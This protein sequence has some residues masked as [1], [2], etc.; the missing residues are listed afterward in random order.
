MKRSELL[1]RLFIAAGTLI[2]VGIPLLFWARTPLIHARMAENGG[3]NPDVLQAEVGK[4]LRLKM[5]SDD[6]VHSFAIGQMDMAP[7]D[8]EPGKVTDITLTFDKPG[9]YTFY[10]TRWCGLNHWRM[11]GTIEVS[12]STSKPEPATIIPLYVTLNLDIDAPHESPAVPSTPP[13]AVRGQQLAAVLDISRFRT[14][15]FYRANSPYQLF[16]ALDSTDLSDS[17]KWDVVSYIWHSNTT[18]EALANGRELY[19]QNCAACHGEGGA[20]NGVFADDLAQAGEASMQTM[21]GA[22]D[23]SMQTPV[24]FTNPKRMLGASPALL[25]GKVL[26]GGMGT[27][28]PMWGS[29]FTE[30]EISDLIAHLYSFQFEYPV[31]E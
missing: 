14:L 10:C 12:G 15:D 9:T 7:I 11:R 21:E 8:V 26:R 4:P 16:E 24:D 28:M 19:A 25:Q 6:V 3:W 30:E 17:E 22:M 31:G 13:S 27:G 1:S 20:G 23:M 2:A 29:I 18:P 5:T